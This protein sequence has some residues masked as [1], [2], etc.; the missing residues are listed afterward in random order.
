M[1]SDPKVIEYLNKG[2]RHELTAINQYWLHYRFLRNWGLLEMAKVWRK[3][4]IEEM[5]HADRITDRIIFLD[6]FPNMQVLD[7]LRIGQN[8]K[9]IIEGD[10]ALEISARSLYEEAATHCHSVRDYVSRDLFED[11]MKDEEHHIDFL[12]TQLD[13][14]GRIGL[15]LYTQSHVGGLE[16]EH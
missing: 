12:E 16:S 8:V 9:E 3:E 5:N 15:E 13:L 1:Q 10:L 6:G 2:L 4:S 7:P 11:L 14:I